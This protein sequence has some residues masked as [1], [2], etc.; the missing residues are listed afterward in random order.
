MIDETLRRVLDDDGRA[1]V[2]TG[3]TNSKVIGNVITTTGDQSGA[4][5]IRGDS[6]SNLISNNEV[7]T[8]GSASNAR[9][10]TACAPTGSPARP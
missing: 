3:G 9:F 7:H 8:S 2:F 5:D 1:I 6:S 10:S 4:F